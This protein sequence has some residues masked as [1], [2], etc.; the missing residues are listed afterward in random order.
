[1]LTVLSKIGSFLFDSSLKWILIA[2][3][4]IGLLI[5]YYNTKLN[6]ADANLEIQ[7]QEQV[8]S[9]LNDNILHLKATISSYEQQIIRQ[10]G[11]NISIQSLLQQCYTDRNSYQEQM[12]KIEM[13]MNTPEPVVTT[14]DEVNYVPVT[15]YQMQQGMEF[16]NS[17]YRKLSPNQ[18]CYR[19]YNYTSY[20]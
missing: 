15:K 19:N 17:Q 13:I 5:L 12:D 9:T 4:F 8:I 3:A 7:K 2:T 6:L 20:H 18:L 14:E 1:M 16:V 11:E 10:E